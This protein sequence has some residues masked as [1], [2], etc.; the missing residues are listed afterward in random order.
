V[1]TESKKAEPKSAGT[2]ISPTLLLVV[3]LMG[4][5]GYLFAFLY[6][7]GGDSGTAGLAVGDSLPPLQAAG[8]VN[9]EP[10]STEGRV[11]VVNAWFINCP[12][13]WKEAP[14]LSELADKYHNE[15]VQFV[16]LSPDPPDNL[17]GVRNFV[18][19]NDL[20]YPNGYGA[21][22]TLQAMNVQ[23]FPGL[24]VV[25]PEGKVIW[26]RSMESRESLEQAIERALA[27]S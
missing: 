22:P 18:E 3:V 16:G 17:E 19:E 21:I 13:C 23:Y 24:W 12:Y 5:A 20:P 1:S 9:G 10:A 6:P 15:G 4:A 7:G 25:G 8:W 14:E 2:G 11:T 27:K 26:N